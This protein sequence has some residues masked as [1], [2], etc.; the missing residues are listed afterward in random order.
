MTDSDWENSKGYEISEWIGQAHDIR[1]IANTNFEDL[2]KVFELNEDLGVNP[3][4]TKQN[5]VF[6]ELNRFIFNY[7]AS[8]RSLIE[9][10]EI[11]ASKIDNKHLSKEDVKSK[12]NKHDLYLRKDFI[13]KL[14]EYYLHYKTPST[15][16]VTVFGDSGEAFDEGNNLIIDVEEFL[17]FCDKKSVREY[18]ESKARDN[19]LNIERELQ[20]FHED[21][22]QYLDWFIPKVRDIKMEH[23]R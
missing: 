3:D 9:Q 6:T 5:V 12:L 23:Y 1:R 20:E 16:N 10:T 11:L 15:G 2:E 7:I 19:S 18:V 21:M 8:A 14:R 13:G 4:L 22:D 17:D